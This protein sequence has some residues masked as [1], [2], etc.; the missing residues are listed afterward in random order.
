MSILLLPPEYL[1]CASLYKSAYI[2]QIQWK[3]WKKL[4]WFNWGDSLGGARPGDGR[5]SEGSEMAM[6]GVQR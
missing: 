5:S 4:H 6:S 2:L 3:N 1:V